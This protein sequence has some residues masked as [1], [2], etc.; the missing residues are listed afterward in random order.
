MPDRHS[1]RSATDREDIAVLVESASEVDRGAGAERLRLRERRVLRKPLGV[2]DI[3]I[4]RYPTVN[5]LALPNFKRVRGA[6]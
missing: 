4:P 6:A 5:G 3:L 1:A 2:V